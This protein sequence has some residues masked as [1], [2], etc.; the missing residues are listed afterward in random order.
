MPA[1]IQMLNAPHVPWP[2]HA[3]RILWSSHDEFFQRE[4]LSHR[5][6][7]LINLW[8]PVGRIGSHVAHVTRV[9]P[10]HSPAVMARVDRAV[11]RHRMPCVEFAPQ[12]VEHWPAGETEIDVEDMNIFSALLLCAVL[13][14]Q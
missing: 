6:E 11:K 5:N 9:S 7:P 4:I 14:S 13:I 1:G 2:A 8:L 10:A 12:R 3:T